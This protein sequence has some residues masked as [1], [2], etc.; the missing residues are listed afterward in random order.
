M[1]FPF[2]VDSYLNSC[3]KYMYFTTLEIFICRLLHDVTH[4]EIILL[5]AA[6]WSEKNENLIFHHDNCNITILEIQL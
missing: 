1:L 3:N 5:Y 4:V 6:L 2:Y